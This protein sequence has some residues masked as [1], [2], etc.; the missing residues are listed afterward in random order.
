MYEP[1][2]HEL[3]SSFPWRPMRGCKGRYLLPGGPTTSSPQ[4]LFGD[5]AFQELHSE[6]APDRVIVATVCGGGIISYAKEDGTFI[7]TLGDSEGF[8]RKL[9]ALWPIR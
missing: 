5:L 4:Q 1:S 8:G 3:L 6:L 7:H 2:F 9:A